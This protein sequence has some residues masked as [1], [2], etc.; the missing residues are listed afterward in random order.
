MKKTLIFIKQN[1]LL[2][3]EYEK[4]CYS[5]AQR[6][7]SSIT[8]ISEE[9][10]AD[11]I[12]SVDEG[13]SY[14]IADSNLYLLLSEILDFDAILLRERYFRGNC[15]RYEAQH[16]INCIGACIFRKLSNAHFDYLIAPPVDNYILDI[17]GVIAE[18][19]GIRVIGIQ[20][21]YLPGMARCSFRGEYNFVRDVPHEEIIE[22]RERYL[23]GAKNS[24]APARAKVYRDIFKYS[25]IYR[26][27]VVLHYHLFYR[28]LGHRRYKYYS[29]KDQVYPKRPIR[30]FRFYKK[31]VTR[32]DNLVSGRRIAYIPLHYFPEAT[33]EYW[34]ELKFVDYYSYL[35]HVV[36]SLSAAGYSIVLKE[37]PA[38]YLKRDV[39]FIKNLLGRE[40]V[41]L[42]SPFVDTREI[43]KLA[44]AT[45]IWTGSTGV[46]SM[47]SDVPT[48]FMS[49]NFYNDG[50]YRSWEELVKE[51]PTI[52]NQ[53]ADIAIKR[54]LETT[55][56]TF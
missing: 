40:H 8:T 36:A 20:R 37:H 15:S 18:H 13:E 30:S 1:K 24:F 41:Y 14:L 5:Y 27:K 35:Q 3:S 23:K 16:L 4:L 56:H 21:F 31:N 17:L 54:L 11:L 22:F 53:N 2:S 29:T 45:V 7:N 43:L 51:K 28:I 48:Y 12:I 46:E 10:K 50:N 25:I 33:V 42:F 55:Y 9:T 49:S 19:L 34:M 26:I 47:M 44:D 38:I 32:I 39:K 52:K 6:L